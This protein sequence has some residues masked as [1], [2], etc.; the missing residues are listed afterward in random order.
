MEIKQ[1]SIKEI[2]KKL[3]ELDEIDLKKISYEKYL[4][5]LKDTFRG[6]TQSLVSM[7]LNSDTSEGGTYGIFRAREVLD[8]NPFSKIEDLWA[9]PAEGINKFGRC[10]NIGESKLYCANHFATTLIECG[11]RE[12]TYWVV[13][14]YDTVEGEKFQMMPVVM[15]VEQFKKPDKLLSLAGFLEDTVYKRNLLIEKYI[16]KSFQRFVPVDQN[17]RYI[18]T[19]AITDY[20]L[21]NNQAKKELFGLIYPS[22]ASKLQGMNFCF[23]SNVALKVLKIKKS[24]Y[25]KFKNIDRGGIHFKT[26]AEGYLSNNQI[27][28][29]QSNQW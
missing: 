26:I 3:R 23:D 27:N 12:G 13:T 14:E 17:L 7:K 2:K 19:C 24:R 1:R 20:L 5:H 21:T 25:I 6:Y 18:K 11:A 4:N 29:S 15:K 9:R 8:G 22:V 10:H 16:R 28:W